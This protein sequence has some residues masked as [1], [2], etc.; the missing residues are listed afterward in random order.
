[1]QITSYGEEIARLKNVVASI[2]QERDV[3]QHEVDV[4]AEELVNLDEGLRQQEK[5]DTEL[6]LSLEELE[7]NL[8]FALIL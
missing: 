8:R 5:A 4:K 7:E 3:L 6:K 2:D 1:M